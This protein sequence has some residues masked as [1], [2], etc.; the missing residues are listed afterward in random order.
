MSESMG[1][2]NR[3]FHLKLY[4]GNALAEYWLN[5]GKDGH[6]MCDH[7]AAAIYFG[8]IN[9]EQIKDYSLGNKEEYLFSIDVAL[10]DELDKGNISEELKG[11][12]K[13][14]G[15]PLSD[16]AIFNGKKGKDRTITT[17]GKEKIIIK[18]E[19]EKLNFYKHRPGQSWNQLKDFVENAK[20]ENRDKIYNLIYLPNDMIYITKAV[21]EVHE[22]KPDDSRYKEYTLQVKKYNVK[23]GE[24]ILKVS[25]QDIVSGPKKRWECPSLVSTV[26]CDTFLNTGTYR[27]IRDEETKKLLS[28]VVSGEKLNIKELKEKKDILNYLGIYEL[29]TLLFLILYH[30]KCRPS[31]WRGGTVEKVD[32]VC[33]PQNKVTIAGKEFTEGILKFQVKRKYNKQEFKRE[34]KEKDQMYY[35]CIDKNWDEDKDSFYLGRDW[36]WD[37]VLESKDEIKEWLK[38]VLSGIDGIES[39]EF[40]Q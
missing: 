5:N 37:A 6:N 12:F 34:K 8:D 11:K 14:K 31:S 13:D 27:E 29:E 24:D 4:K 10:E 9:L 19:N 35:V 3:Y 23:T 26:L 2:E 30:N 20:P 16:D 18:K 15:Y 40:N 32:I 28:K 39:L 22:V 21:S 33:H 36:L 1:N 38:G 25:L 17:T 7:P